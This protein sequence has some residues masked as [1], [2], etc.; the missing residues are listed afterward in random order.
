MNTEPLPAECATQEED[1][2]ALERYPWVLPPVHADYGFNIHIGEDVFLN[3]NSTFIDTCPINIGARTLIGPNCS[4]LGGNHPLDPAV[5]DGLNGPETGKP[6]KISEDCW[7]GANVTILAGVSIGKGA[8][9]GAGSVVTK[10][11]IY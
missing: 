2:A 7:L 8:T 1:D 5:R 11:C 9:V 4:F 6:I 10:A 3:Y